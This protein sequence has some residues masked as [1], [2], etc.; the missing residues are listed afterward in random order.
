MWIF[1]SKRRAKKLKERFDAKLD[2]I[3]CRMDMDESWLDR[4]LVDR[5]TAEYQQ[6]FVDPDPLVTV[7]IATYNR[8]DLLTQRTI[9]SVLNQTWKNI[10]LIVVG[11]ACIDNTPELIAKIDDPRLTFVNLPER[12]VYPRDPKFRWMVAGTKPTNEAMKM[13]KGLFVTHLDDD[14]A[15]AP[16]RIEKLVKFAQRDQLEFVWHPF[17]WEKQVNQW[18]VFSADTFSA[19]CVTN[20]SAFYHRWLTNIPLDI[21][22]YRFHEPFD[23]NRFRKF[24]YLG[25]KAARF[26]EPLLY[27]YVETQRR[28]DKR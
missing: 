2:I 9:P 3:K 24:K 20:A 11:D 21:N 10:Q 17:H 27:H 18:E 15:Y 6:P 7:C 23:W 13:A 26:P 8:G 16:D 1:S 4:Y 19:N 22:A 14:D 12:G 5:L 28:E 25:V